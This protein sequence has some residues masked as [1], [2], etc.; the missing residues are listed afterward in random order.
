VEDPIAV[1]LKFAFIAVLYLFLLWVARSALRDLRGTRGQ[2][3]GPEYEDATAMHRAGSVLDAPG[4]LPRLRVDSAPGLRTGAVYDLSSGALLG[5]GG[6]ADIV[7]E[8][9][10]SS[11]RHARL[12]PQGDAIVLEDLGST[13]GT[14]L[15]EEPLSGPQPLHDGDRIKIGGSE[16]TFERA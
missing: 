14:Y 8:D 16:F 1:L 3:A 12:I 7:L 13:N 5:R 4:G 10:F 11:T 9:S 2:A 6:D 15:N